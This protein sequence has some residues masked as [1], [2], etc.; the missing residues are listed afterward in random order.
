MLRL[1]VIGMHVP[2]QAI[3]DAP[4]LCNC[5]RMDEMIKKTVTDLAFVNSGT[6]LPTVEVDAQ[7]LRRLLY[8]DRM[9]V[10]CV[11]MP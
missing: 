9:A 6:P 10:L 2:R 3:A 4:S 5:S 8:V 7:A 11:A 1:P